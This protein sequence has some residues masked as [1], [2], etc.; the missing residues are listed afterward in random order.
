MAKGIAR[1]SVTFGLAGCY[2]PDDGPHAMEFTSRRELAEF[3]R[4]ELDRLEWPKSAFAQA[5]IR[6]VWSRIARRGSSV[7]DFSIKHGGHELSFFGLTDD[8]F[9]FMTREREDQFA[10]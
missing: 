6:R 4:D 1:Y 3:I 2:M 9:S 7:A 5:N 10:V 8:E